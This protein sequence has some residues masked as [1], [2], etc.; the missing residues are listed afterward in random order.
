MS[1]WD[2]TGGLA[3]PTS[4]HMT[5]TGGS[6]PKNFQESAP[7]ALGWQWLSHGHCDGSDDVTSEGT[8]I[9][10]PRTLGF[11]D[12]ILYCLWVGG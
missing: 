12:P 9:R 2:A 7:D 4:G 8:Q 1:E 11:S 10:F 3:Q 5:G 6:Q